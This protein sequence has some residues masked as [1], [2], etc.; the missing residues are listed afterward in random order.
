MIIYGYAYLTGGV[1][2]VYITIEDGIIKKIS[3]DALKG[4][5]R[6]FDKHGNIIF[7]GMIDIHV[8]MRDFDQ[9]YKEDFYSGTSAAAAG[10]V[11]IVMDMPNTR[12]RNNRLDTLKKREGVAD[13]S[14]VVD[15]GLYYGLP[16]RENELYNYEEYAWGLKIYPEDYDKP[17]LIKALK[18]N[19]ENKLLTVIHPEDPLDISEGHRGLGCELRAIARFVEL[20]IK[21]CYKLHFTHITSLNSILLSRIGRPNT[22]VDTCPHYLLLNNEDYKPPYYRVNPPLRNK[23]IQEHLLRGITNIKVDAI[24]TDHAPHTFEEKIGEDS[25]PGFPG[26]ETCLPILITL[27]KNGFISLSDIT[28]MYSSGPAKIL[29]LNRYLGSIAEGK[30]ANL[31]ICNLNEE[32]T[33]NPDKFFS[34]AKHTPFKSLKVFGRVLATIVRG[35][36]AYEDGEILVNKGYGRNIRRLIKL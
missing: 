30:L 34:K 8:H 12:P 31:V 19:K 13:K 5:V 6:K 4:G 9:S 27:F 1:E 16:D 24:S 29:G 14:A 22:T 17:S 2:K 18:Y 20:S 11:C 25:I 23:Y 15:Y 7:P 33:I 10:G 3:K 26:L 21:H 28:T 32:Y 35:E 36:F